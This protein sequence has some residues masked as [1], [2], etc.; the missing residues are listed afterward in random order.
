MI[1]LLTV[2]ILAITAVMP[3]I[4]WQLNRIHV[5]VNSAMTA[6]TERAERAEAAL[7][8]HGIPIPPLPTDRQG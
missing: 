6:V 7:I 5:L 4:L 2:I 1:A 3:L 8:K